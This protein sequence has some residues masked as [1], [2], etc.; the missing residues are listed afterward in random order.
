MMEIN[1]VWF[2][3]EWNNSLFIDYI[4]SLDGDVEMGKEKDKL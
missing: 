4:N 1:G 2:F 3:K